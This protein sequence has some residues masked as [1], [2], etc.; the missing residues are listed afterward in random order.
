MQGSGSG[1]GSGMKLPGHCHGCCRKKPE[2]VG[3]M[4]L[5]L[6][7]TAKGWMDELCVGGVSTSHVG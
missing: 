5:I 6:F 2:L 7:E 3:R 4:L 1:S